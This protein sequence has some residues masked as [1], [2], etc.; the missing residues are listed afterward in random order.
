[1]N[2][3][4]EKEQQANADMNHKHIVE[5]MHRWYYICLKSISNVFEE[6]KYVLQRPFLF[7]L[8]IGLFE[9]YSK[10]VFNVLYLN[11]MIDI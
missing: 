4:V 3:L 7:Y 6:R 8:K 10:I 5:R 11:I 1:M 9:G 2:I